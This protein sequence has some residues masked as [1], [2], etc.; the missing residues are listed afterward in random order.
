MLHSLVTFNWLENNLNDENLVVLYTDLIAKSESIP[1]TLE[2]RRIKGARYFDLKNIF[3]EK[4]SGLP[5][6]YPSAERF[7]KGCQELGI[8]ENSKIVVYDMLGVYSSP[9]VWFLFKSMGHKNVFV[10][11]G[12]LKQWVEE[13]FK[14][15]GIKPITIFKGNFKAKADLSFVKFKQDVEAN[16]NAKAFQVIDA[17]SAKRFKGDSPE[18]RPGLRSGNISGSCNLHYARLLQNGKYKPREELRQ[19][20]AELE[21]NKPIVFSCGSGITACI[22]YLVASEILPNEISIYDG[23]WTEWGSTV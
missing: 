18:P 4:E 6:T 22:L 1:T 14:T 11:N 3:S 21:V 8:N 10:L 7:E 20:F 2:T 13:G 15:E 9:R 17:R 16:V 19:I 5:N 12:G 23:S